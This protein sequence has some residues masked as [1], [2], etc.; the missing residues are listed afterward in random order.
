MNNIVTLESFKKFDLI[1]IN[2]INPNQNSKNNCLLGTKCY[3]VLN[4]KENEW[5][6]LLS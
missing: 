6:S 4:T 3:G 5:F 2:G 1:S